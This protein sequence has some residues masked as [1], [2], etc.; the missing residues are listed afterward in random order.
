MAW[1]EIAPGKRVPFVWH[2]MLE[3]VKKLVLKIEGKE[4]RLC[5]D[6]MFTKSFSTGNDTVMLS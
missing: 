4:K 1:R 6:R 2:N 5:I 3:P